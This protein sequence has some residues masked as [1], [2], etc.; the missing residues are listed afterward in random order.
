MATLQF[1]VKEAT[2]ADAIQKRVLEIVGGSKISCKP[3]TQAG[4]DDLVVEC[5]Y[6]LSA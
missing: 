5:K 2:I 1:L 4:S 6:M 3:S